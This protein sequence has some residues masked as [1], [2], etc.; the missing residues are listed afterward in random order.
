MADAARK[1]RSRTA[2]PPEAAPPSQPRA[3]ACPV[4]FCPICIAVT[5]TQPIRAEVLEHLLAAGRELLL[6]VQAAASASTVGKDEDAS[7]GRLEKIELG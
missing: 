5:G 7:G 6:A 3:A 2:P 4:T 1:K